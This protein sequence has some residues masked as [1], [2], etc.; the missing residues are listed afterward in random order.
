MWPTA[1][2]AESRDRVETVAHLLRSAGTELPI[3]DA[4]LDVAH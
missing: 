3:I 4:Y 2:L 1:E